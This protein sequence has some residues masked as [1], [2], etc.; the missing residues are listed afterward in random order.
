MPNRMRLDPRIRFA[1]RRIGIALKPNG[2]GS[3][4]G[5]HSKK[6]PT[7]EYRGGGKKNGL[8]RVGQEHKKRLRQAPDINSENQFRTET[9]TEK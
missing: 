9:K 1:V 4:I 2:E 7:E 6:K 3:H 5:E 8:R